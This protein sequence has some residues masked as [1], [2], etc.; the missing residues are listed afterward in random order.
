MHIILT[1]FCVIALALIFWA[2]VRYHYDLKNEK[3]LE[4]HRNKFID[5]PE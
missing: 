3:P 1:V 5:T 4:K 2:G